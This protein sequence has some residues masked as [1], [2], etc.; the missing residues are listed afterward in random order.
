MKRLIGGV[1]SIEFY[2]NTSRKSNVFTLE[3]RYLCSLEMDSIF[4][5][6]DEYGSPDFEEKDYVSINRIFVQRLYQFS[7]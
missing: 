4:K 2:L 7:M 5:L 6:T 1:G 3:L